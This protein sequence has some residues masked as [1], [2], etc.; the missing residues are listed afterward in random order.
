MVTRNEFYKLLKHKKRFDNRL[1][2]LSRFLLDKKDF[3]TDS[4]PVICRKCGATANIRLKDYPKIS[5]WERD[6]CC[7]TTGNFYVIKDCDECGWFE[8][9]LAYDLVS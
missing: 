2:K 1:G 5:F 8:F 3:W 4:L 7:G 9:D 6:T